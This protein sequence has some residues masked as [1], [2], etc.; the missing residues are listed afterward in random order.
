MKRQKSFEGSNGA[1]YVVGTPIGN[2]EDL[3][4]RARNTLAEVDRIACEDTRR[5]RKLLSHLEISVPLVSYHEHNRFSR[6]EELSERMEQGERIALVSD[7][8][9]PALS[10]PGEELVREAVNRGIPVIPV[11]GPNAALSAVVASGIPPQPFLFIGF[12]PRQTKERIR[13]LDR[14]KEVPATLLF[15]EAPHRILP[16]LRDLREV[17]GDRSTAIAREVT[18]KHEE[19]IRGTLSQC[20]DWFR[21]HS[22]RGEMTVVVSGAK[23]SSPQNR[24]SHET[25]WWH[26]LSVTEHVDWHIHRGKAKKEAIRTVA[27]E[28]SLPK[29]EVYNHYHQ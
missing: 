4:I 24:E 10:D 17:L 9:M 18:K 29:R 15:Y 14:W 2:L 25:D 8:G 27:K 19:W 3:S 21:E 26:P 11:P 16:M 1:L 20:R 23:D 22:P 5:T 7:A 28:R 13:E 12:L 6:M